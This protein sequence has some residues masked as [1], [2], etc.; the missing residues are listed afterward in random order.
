VLLLAQL[1]LAAVAGLIHVPSQITRIDAALDAAAPG[2][3]VLVAAGT[4][5]ENILWPLTPGIKLLSESGAE[6][7]VIDGRYKDMVI[8][9]Y[10]GVDTTT[11]IRGFTIAGGFAAG[12]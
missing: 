2:D 9:I 4:Y 5:E 6:E 1:P 10:T 7:T 8:G 3:T 12:A 11:V